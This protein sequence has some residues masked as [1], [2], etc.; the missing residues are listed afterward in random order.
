[1]KA[2]MVKG[3]VAVRMTCGRCRSPHEQV[4]AD[5]PTWATNQWPP[6]IEAYFG[7]CVGCGRALGGG[8][9]AHPAIAS[10]LPVFA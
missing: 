4:V 8:A 9:V 3:G 5:A 10:V 1:V 6:L 2:R 7:S